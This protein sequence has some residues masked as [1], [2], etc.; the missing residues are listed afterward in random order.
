MDQADA[1]KRRTLSGCEPTLAIPENVA[2]LVLRT[3]ETDQEWGGPAS[4]VTVDRVLMVRSKRPET[5]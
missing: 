5:R 2:P 4:V 1:C 3:M